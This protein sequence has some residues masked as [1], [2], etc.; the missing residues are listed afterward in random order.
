[1]VLGCRVPAPFP[2]ALRSKVRQFDL[3][4]TPKLAELHA[5]RRRRNEQRRETARCLSVNTQAS[6]DKLAK[7]SS[8][9]A[10]HHE[11]LL[12][13]QQRRSEV[14]NKRPGSAEIT[15]HRTE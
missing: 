8:A 3:L 10:Q 5:K 12:G 15:T 9:S 14:Y 7:A 4:T 11:I 1:M 6:D 2:F 13:S